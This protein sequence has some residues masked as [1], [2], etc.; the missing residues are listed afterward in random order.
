M[1]TTN[2]RRH[3]WRQSCESL[4]ST[5]G[6]DL[7]GIPNRILRR[8]ACRQRQN[9]RRALLRVINTLG[10]RADCKSCWTVLLT[11]SD[12][13]SSLDM[14]GWRVDARRGG[15]CFRLP[16]T[17]AS[18]PMTG[19]DRELSFQVIS[20]NSDFGWKLGAAACSRSSLPCL[21]CL[22][23][24]RGDCLPMRRCGSTSKRITSNR[25]AA[26]QR[27]HS[28]LS[29]EQRGAIRRREEIQRRRAG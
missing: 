9:R 13:S 22:T 8:R 3:H 26:P 1:H 7:A 25:L 28:A 23:L 5:L 29:S 16:P 6:S 27:I 20:T 24:K 14:I 4:R 10:G 21:F 2:S 11:G 12:P 18:N 19:S 17:L 15:C